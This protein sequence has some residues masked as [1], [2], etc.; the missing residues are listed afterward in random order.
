MRDLGRLVIPGAAPTF[1][2]GDFRF[3]MCF[4]GGFPAFDGAAR[5]GL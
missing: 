5:A 3:Q 4:T 1:G 2:A